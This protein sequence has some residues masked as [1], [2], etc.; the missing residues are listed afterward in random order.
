MNAFE[1][2]KA[3]VIEFGMPL[4]DEQV[5]AFLTYQETL[6]EWNNKINLTAI[7]DPQE[8]AVK[9]F[10]DS[11]SCYDPDIFSFGCS[12][13]DVGTGAGFPGIPLK[14]Y[15]PDIRLCLID[16][17]QKR[18]LFLQTVIQKLGLKDVDIHHMRA[19]EAGRLKTNRACFD[20]AVS[21]AVARLS[22]LCELCLPLVRVNGFFIAMKGAKFQDEI[23]EAKSALSLL[24]GSIAHIKE[25]TLPGLEDVRAIIY[26][27]K[28]KSTPDK[29]PRRAGIPEKNPL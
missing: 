19:E 24:G 5:Q 11:L 20:V 9:H 13:V 4:S 26:I 25:I 10:V 7:T 27:Q 17:L 16:S 1:H 14:I 22:V 21:R 12:V 18:T 29:Y 23:A 8:I 15:R 6:L 3:A 28:V 2:L